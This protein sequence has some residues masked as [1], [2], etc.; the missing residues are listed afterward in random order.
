M[1]DLPVSGL[2]SSSIVSQSNILPI[3]QGGITN[4]ITAENLGKGIFTFN[5]PYSPFNI[6]YI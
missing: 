5:L 4:K 3:V 2:P 6:C 1:P